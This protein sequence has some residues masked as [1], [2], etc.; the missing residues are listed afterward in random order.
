MAQKVEAPAARSG[1]KGGSFKTRVVVR[2]VGPLSVLKL[3]LIFYAC[4][5]LV[6]LLALVMLY[7]IV[8][9]A[10]VIDSFASLAGGVGLGNCRDERVRGEIQEM[11]T[12]A[13]NGGWLFARAALI[14][15]GLVVVWS[16]INVFVAFL[17]N[18][19]SDV[20]GGLE[21]TLSDKR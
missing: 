15:G 7:G 14:A 4:V 11:C 20:V 21:L 19:I 10:G 13:V 18:L 17:Y 8:S 12:F 3:S 2:K 5:A 6:I 9:A 16:V 1:R